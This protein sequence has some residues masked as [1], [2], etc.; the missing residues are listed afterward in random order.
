LS[1]LPRACTIERKLFLDKPSG[2]EIK[3]KS[4]QRSRDIEMPIKIPF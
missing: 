1:S 4:Q 2:V 3:K